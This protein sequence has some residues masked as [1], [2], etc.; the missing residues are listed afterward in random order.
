MET[1]GPIQYRDF[2]DV[3]R[4]FIVKYENSTLL[5]DSPF[6]DITDEYTQEYSVYL[7]HNPSKDDLQGDWKVLVSKAERLLGRVPVSKVQF[8]LT[9][10]KEIN[11]EIF[12][13]FDI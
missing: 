4:I 5:F 3:P 8:D 9:K 2:Y 6:D 12:A 7:I 10:R 1:W 13:D 11:L